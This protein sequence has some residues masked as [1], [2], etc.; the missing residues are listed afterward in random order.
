M[1]HIEEPP[2]PSGYV[3]KINNFQLGVSLQTQSSSLQKAQFT[4]ARI[5]SRIE[6]VKNNEVKDFYSWSRLS[7]KN[8]LIHGHY[9]GPNVT[10]T[11]LSL[12]AGV[13]RYLK[14]D[15]SHTTLKTY[16][17][18]L[19]YARLHF[20]NSRKIDDITKDMIQD[21]IWGDGGTCLFNLKVQRTGRALDLSSIK[22]KVQRLKQ[23]FK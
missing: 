2:R 9:Q 10:T 20:G 1:A 15:L 18:E 11:E 19:K 22:K 14:R 17:S 3:I 4:L 5:T 13:D 16:I 6:Q 8:Y 23:L 21:W 12:S 7:K